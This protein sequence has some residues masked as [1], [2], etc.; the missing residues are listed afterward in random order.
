M[1]TTRRREK[2]TVKAS[3]PV[4][5]GANGYSVGKEPLSLDGL[6]VSEEEYWAFY[7]EKADTDTDT[8]YEWNNGILEEKPMPDYRRVTLYGWFLMLL[9]AYLETNPVGKLLFLEV[10][11]RLALPDKTTIRKPDLFVIRNDNP[12]PLADTDRS[13]RGICDFCVES[14]SVSTKKDIERDTVVKKREY[15]GIGVQEDYILDPDDR[16]VFYQR[17]P[18]GVYEE[19]KADAEGIL[20]SRVLPGFQ[21]RVTDLFSMPSLETLAQDPVY[22]PFVL[23]QY[24]AA[25]QQIEV[26]KERAEAAEEQAA[27]EK[28]RADRYADLLR[29]KGIPEE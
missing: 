10:G 22:S 4:R 5:I 14:L 24:Q 29:A 2:P 1:T 12:V 17:T 23:L 3:E 27:L 18:A 19:M 8:S 26:V 21:F 11:F 6:A 15:K 20:R 25:M 28:A 7:Y 9:R 16:T 13:Y